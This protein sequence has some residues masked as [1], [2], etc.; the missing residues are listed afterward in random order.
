MRKLVILPALMFLLL[1]LSG[2]G[3]TIIPQPLDPNDRVNPSDRSIT[4]ERTTLHLTARVQ[5]TAVGGFS[6]DTPLT[7]FYIDA[8]NND[9]KPLALPLLSFSLIDD[10]GRV[11]QAVAPSAVNALLLPEYDYLVPF[12][13][14]SYLDVT[15]QE[16]QRAS[17]AMQS[18]QPYAMSRGLEPGPS[19]TP[20]PE[21][22]I[23]AG[24]RAA[25]VIFFEIDLYMVASVRLQVSNPAGD[26]PFVF[27]FSIKK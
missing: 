4:I 27:P 23:A 13:Y 17:S 9:R 6:T 22:N 24:A 18:E 14:V 3:L 12:P 7:S 16:I 11:Y 2:C 19:G 1:I 5:D 15:A 26:T 20:F 10:Q 25:G 21:I 8:L